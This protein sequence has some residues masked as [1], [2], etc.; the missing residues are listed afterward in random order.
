MILQNAYSQILQNELS[1]GIEKLYLYLYLFIYLYKYLCC[2]LIYV[3][4]LE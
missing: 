3:C 1:M 2:K 4:Q